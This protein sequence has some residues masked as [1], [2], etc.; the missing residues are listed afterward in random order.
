MK[1]NLSSV[2]RI[3]R[4][5]IAAVIIVLYFTTNLIAGTWAIILLIVSGSFITTSFISFC[6]LY[7]LFGI[8]SNRQEKNA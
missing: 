7:F 8:N 2:D 6:P 5:L 1:K 4:I 3:F